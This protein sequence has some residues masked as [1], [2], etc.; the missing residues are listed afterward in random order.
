LAE[1]LA[2]LGRSTSAALGM[3]QDQWAQAQAE[4]EDRGRELDNAYELVTKQE[5]EANALREEIAQ[6]K[7]KLVQLQASSSPCTPIPTP[8]ST[9]APV[10]EQSQAPAPVTQVSLPCPVPSPLV[11]VRG[12]QASQWLR[13]R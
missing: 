10:M 9:A 5:E 13:Y 6:L 3:L 12:V 8:R 1:R 7:L 2:R 4:L 11:N